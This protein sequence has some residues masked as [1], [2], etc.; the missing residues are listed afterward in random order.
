MNSKILEADGEQVLVFIENNCGDTDGY[1]L[2][3]IYWPKEETGVFMVD[4]KLSGIKESD[5]GLK[6]LRNLIAGYGE[7]H[8]R[9]IIGQVNEMLGVENAA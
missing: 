4:F 7:D 1:T 3:N 8:A 2:H 9:K 5:E 6:S